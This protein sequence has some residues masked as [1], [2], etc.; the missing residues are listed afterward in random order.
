MSIVVDASVVVRWF[1]AELGS[2]AALGVLDKGTLIAPDILPAEVRQCLDAAAE[3]GLA[4][5]N[6]AAD[7]DRLLPTLAL[8]MVPALHH[9]SRAFQLSVI[10]SQPIYACVYLAVAESMHAQL[11]TADAAFAAAV[12]RSERVKV[13][14]M[15]ID[16]ELALAS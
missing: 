7:F 14:V 8:D 9:L 13:P 1:V 3:Q 10:L 2:V 11:A 16:E 15:M 5:A 6:L 4:P 12:R